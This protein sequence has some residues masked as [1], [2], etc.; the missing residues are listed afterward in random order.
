MNNKIL[1]SFFLFLSLCGIQFAT[2]QPGV[3][4]YI[5]GC[6]INI[7]S[8]SSSSPVVTFEN[9]LFKATIRENAGADCGTEHA[10]RDWAIKSNNLNQAGEYIDACAQRGPLKKASIIFERADSAK[11]KLEY[12][13]CK[14]GGVNAVSEYTFYE[15]SPFIKIGY[16]KIP[17]G[18]WNTVDIGQPG[19]Q[20]KG[21][22]KIYGQQNYLRTIQQYPDSYW[23][24]FDI[25]Y[26]TDPKNGGTLNYKGYMI[27]LVGDTN[28]GSGFGRIM[29]IKTTTSGG[30]TILKL[31]NYR[32]FETFPGTGGKAIPYSAAIFVFDNGLTNAM[33]QAKNYIDKL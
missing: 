12:T 17:D 4:A 10:I 19:G 8:D 28:N 33:A 23:N 32:G 11:I 31:L 18:W 15:N 24:T 30:I 25:E 27:M 5:K 1:T 13:D 20:M 9:A 7:D 29:P 6:K 26:A 14:N 2:T 3:K 21:T 16:V 22:Y